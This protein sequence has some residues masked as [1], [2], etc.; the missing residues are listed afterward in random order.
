MLKKKR[1]LYKL[2]SFNTG[3]IKINKKEIQS[4][5]TALINVSRVKILLSL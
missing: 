3:K 4:K 2:T 1:S 5:I